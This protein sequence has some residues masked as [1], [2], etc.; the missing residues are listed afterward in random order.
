MIEIQVS[1]AARLT[2][3]RISRNFCTIYTTSFKAHGSQAQ[4]SERNSR[5]EETIQKEAEEKVLICYKLQAPS[6]T[7]QQSQ[8]IDSMTGFVFNESNSR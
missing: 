8:H 3:L 2:L 4:I 7:L 1:I 5:K 6:L